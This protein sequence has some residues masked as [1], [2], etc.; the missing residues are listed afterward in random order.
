RGSLDRALP[1]AERGLALARER[2][3]P[4]LSPDISD[5]LGHAYALSGR[6]AESLAA[7]EEGLAAM[8]NMGM[9]QWRTPLLVHL[10]EA[11]LLAG[12]RN[13]ALA[14]GEGGRALARERRHRGAERAARP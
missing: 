6:T 12:R 4:Q 1:P 9:F 2:H 13:D 7:L 14:Q 11:Y 5:Q 10:G 3:L 8:K